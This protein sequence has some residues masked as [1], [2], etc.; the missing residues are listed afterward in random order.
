MTGW[1]A[2]GQPD[3]LDD[4]GTRRCRQQAPASFQPPCF[5]QGTRR[6]KYL[7]ENLGAAGVALSAEELRELDEAFPKEQVG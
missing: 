4:S 1:Q 2:G 5:P 7:R 3:V 6:V